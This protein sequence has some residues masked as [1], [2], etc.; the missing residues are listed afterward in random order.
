MFNKYFDKYFI[1]EKTEDFLMKY[2]H[3]KRVEE[4]KYISD[5][6]KIKKKVSLYIRLFV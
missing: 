1:L 3:H 5:N 4:E 2:Y 6:Y